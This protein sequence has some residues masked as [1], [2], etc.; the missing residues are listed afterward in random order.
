MCHLYVTLF[1]ISFLDA[2]SDS[3]SNVAG[4][5][6]M[7][8]NPL[9]FYQKIGA[10]RNSNCSTF[11]LLFLLASV[12]IHY[13][14]GNVLTVRPLEFLGSPPHKRSFFHPF[15]TMTPQNS[16]PYFCAF[17]DSTR[18]RIILVD[19]VYLFGKIGRFLSRSILTLKHYEN[20]GAKGRNSPRPSVVPVTTEAAFAYLLMNRLTYTIPLPFWNLQ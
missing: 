15:S 10:F 5:R 18:R 3:I 2:S 11:V 1:Y 8:T 16:V 19:V 9:C 6:L 4:P 7:S 13:N 14:S 17:H 12:T 20:R